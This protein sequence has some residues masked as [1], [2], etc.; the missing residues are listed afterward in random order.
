MTTGKPSWKGGANVEILAEA[1]CRVPKHPLM[2]TPMLGEA[3][4]GF[5]G[6][7]V[8]RQARAEVGPK[9]LAP[10][11]VGV[12]PTSLSVDRHVIQICSLICMRGTRSKRALM[13]GWALLLQNY[14][15]PSTRSWDDWCISTIIDA[16]Q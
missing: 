1:L 3:R 10:L 11:A 9:F 6:K 14:G 5:G 2:L 13:K 7:G 15:Y 12:D 16:P 4:R 8:C